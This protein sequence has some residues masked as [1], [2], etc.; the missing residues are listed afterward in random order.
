MTMTQLVAMAQAMFCGG[1]A[2]M[3][4]FRFQRNGSQYRFLSSL[5]AFGL[6]S[7]LGMQWMSI[8]GRILFYGEWP[9]VSP[10]NTMVFG[11]LFVLIV[12]A[13]GNV[14]RVFNFEVKQ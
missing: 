3:I 10:Y 12:R 7:L 2:F 8:L 1:I 13:R 14:S 6:A 9:Y 4:A 5:C 11:I